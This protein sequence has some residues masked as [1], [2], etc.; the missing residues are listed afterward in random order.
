MKASELRIGNLVTVDNPIYH[1][2]LKGIAL[3]V[4][5]LNQRPDMSGNPSY[6]I[7]LEHINQK[8]YTYYENYSQL[9][10]FINPIPLSEDWLLKAGFEKDGHG[11][12]MEDIYSLS[13]SVT[14]KGEFLPCWLDRPLTPYNSDKFREVKYVHQLQNLYF[15]LTG[16]ELTFKM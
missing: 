9:V 16:E 15:A 11:Y 2:K 4:T 1:P 3:Q 13:I 5:G 14:R 12:H 6:S 7:S 8:P 10:E